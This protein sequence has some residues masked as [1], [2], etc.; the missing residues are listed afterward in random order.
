M[1][2]LMRGGWKRSRVLGLPSLQRTAWT[3]PDQS[4]TA[5]VSYSTF[6]LGPLSW[7]PWPARP[8]RNRGEC[9]PHPGRQT[10]GPSRS[11]GRLVSQS[12]SSHDS[13]RANKTS[14]RLQHLLDLERLG[15]EAAAPL[16]LRTAATCVGAELPTA[17]RPA[18]RAGHSL[19]HHRRWPPESPLAPSQGRL[20]PL[21][22]VL[23]QRFNRVSQTRMYLPPLVP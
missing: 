1:H 9:R 15:T 2:G 7:T 5:P 16:G 10:V 11:R 17:P 23:P 20:D 19:S 6:G 4:T 22:D 12:A 18:S 21:P 14:D 8:Q 13:W 3:A